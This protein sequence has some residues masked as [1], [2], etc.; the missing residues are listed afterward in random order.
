MPRPYIYNKERLYF[1]NP[2]FQNRS[3]PLN[4]GTVVTSPSSEEEI[5]GG[6]YVICDGVYLIPSDILRTYFRKIYH[7]TKFPLITQLR[8]IVT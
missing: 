5:D 4:E 2:T 6:A 1:G 7:V 3:R 8:C